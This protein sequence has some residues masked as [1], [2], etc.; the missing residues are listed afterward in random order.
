MALSPASAVL[1]KR[2]NNAQQALERS[3]YAAPDRYDPATWFTAD[4]AVRLRAE[5][6]G[7]LVEVEAGEW[8]EE[9]PDRVSWQALAWSTAILFWRWM[10]CLRLDNESSCM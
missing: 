10:H 5:V 7:R 4:H 9:K 8:L 1:S 6:H 3:S 2:R